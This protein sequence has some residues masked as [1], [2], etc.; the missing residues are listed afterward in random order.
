MNLDVTPLFQIVAAGVAVVGYGIAWWFQPKRRARRA[1]EH[2]RTKRLGEVQEGE[3][4]GITGV[5]RRLKRTLVS[6]VTGRSCL[7]YRFVIEERSEGWT[8]AVERS[9][10]VPFGL[11]AE[12][13]EATVEGPFLFGLDFDDRGDVWANLPPGLFRV[14]EEAGV[15]LSGPFG[16]EKEFRFREAVLR[17][18]DRISVLGRVSIE[19][20]RSGSREAF[21]AL[22]IRRIIRGSARELVALAD[23]DDELDFD[24]VPPLPEPA[25]R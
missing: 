8:T 3:R 11:V 10:C 24:P 14:L 21:R 5:A 4:V 22:P 18:D 1:L 23:A 2:A 12:G 15:S 25:R 17:P 13:V 16:G 6:P 9:N 20:D 19:V 7:G